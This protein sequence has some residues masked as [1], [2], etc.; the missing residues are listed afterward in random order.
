MCASSGNAG[1]ASGARGSCADPKTSCRR[2]LAP[3][4]GASGH[5]LRATEAEAIDLNGVAP[6]AARKSAF[7]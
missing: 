6:Q 3:S 1:G 7:K 2:P 4:G 5:L